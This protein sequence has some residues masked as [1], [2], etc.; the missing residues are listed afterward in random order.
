MV[1]FESLVGGHK[2]VVTYDLEKFFSSLDVKSTHTEPRPAQ[3]EAMR[4]L[5]GMHPVS[6]TP[7]LGVMMQPEVFHGKASIQS[8][9]SICKR[10]SE[11]TNTNLRVV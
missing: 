2:E 11:A 1:D 4:E 6:Q 9:I 3:R 7:C 8:L 5:T 10:C